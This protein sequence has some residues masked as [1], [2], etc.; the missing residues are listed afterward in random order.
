MHS[1]VTDGDTI[2]DIAGKR[3]TETGRNDDNVEEKGA[4]KRRKIMKEAVK[5]QNGPGLRRT[6]RKRK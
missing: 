5:S 1:E 3:T 4:G 6:G 2:G